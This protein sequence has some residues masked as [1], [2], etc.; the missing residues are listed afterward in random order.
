MDVFLQSAAGGTHLALAGVVLVITAADWAAV[1]CSGWTLGGRTAAAR[2]IVSGVHHTVSTV[3]TSQCRAWI[4][5]RFTHSHL[6]RG[7]GGCRSTGGGSGRRR[8]RCRRSTNRPTYT[9]TFTRGGRFT[10]SCSACLGLTTLRPPQLRYR[11]A[12]RRFLRAVLQNLNFATFLIYFLNRKVLWAPNVF[13]Q[14]CLIGLY[15]APPARSNDWKQTLQ[16]KCRIKRKP[17]PPSS[18]ILC[19]FYRGAA[20]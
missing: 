18:E 19:P 4:N 13:C 20:M 10:Q 2:L 14:H 15:P 7:C 5:F 3:P 9:H 8:R 12:A 11:T 1:C 6:L 16:K 17:S